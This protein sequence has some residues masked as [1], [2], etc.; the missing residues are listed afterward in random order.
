MKTSKKA[1]AQ[2]TELQDDLNPAYLFSTTYNDLLLQI[3]RGEIDPRA[4]AAQTLA[5]RG[6][7]LTTGLWVGFKTAQQQ[8]TEF[9]KTLK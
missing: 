9:I 4:L 2:T 8:A 6:L 1:N 3:T 5:N 7:D